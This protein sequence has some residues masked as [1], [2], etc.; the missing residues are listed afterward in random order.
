[1]MMTKRLRTLLLC[2]MAALSEATSGQIRAVQDPVY[3]YY[4]QAYPGDRKLSS[5][6]SSHR[7]P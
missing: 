7:I 6:P 4:L 3:H 2:G 5:S 1:M